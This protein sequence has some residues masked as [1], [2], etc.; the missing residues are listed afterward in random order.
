MVTRGSPG[1]FG[2]THTQILLVHIIEPLPIT[3]SSHTDN[4]HFLHVLYVQREVSLLNTPG[5]NSPETR[6]S[7]NVVCRFGL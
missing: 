2:H 5:K 4:W 7:L 1:R 3:T 6:C